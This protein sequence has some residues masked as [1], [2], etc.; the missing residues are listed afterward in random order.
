MKRLF[1]KLLLLCFIS[2][3][4]GAQTW[5][6]KHDYPSPVRTN[7]ISFTIGNFGYY[8]SGMRGSA[9]SDSTDMMKYDV[10][11]DTWAPISPL[12][13]RLLSA[14]SFSIGQY[15][16]VGIGY[17]INELP[18]GFGYDNVGT[19]SLFYRYDPMS[20]SWSTVAGFPLSS[21][22]NPS[23]FVLNGLGYVAG[24]LDS[25]RLLPQ[26]LLYSYNPINNNWAQLDSLPLHIQG[27]SGFSYNGFGYTADGGTSG[28][29]LSKGV[30]KYNASSNSWDTLSSFPGNSA[31]GRYCNFVLD[32]AIYFCNDN[33]QFWKYSPATDTWQRLPDTPFK[34]AGATFILHGIPVVIGE[35]THEVWQLCP[36]LHVSAGSEI[37]ICKGT[38]TTLLASG[39]VNYS[40][41]PSAGLTNPNSYNPGAAPS[42]TTMYVVTVTD[43]V[44]CIGRDSVRV[45]VKIVP[46]QPLISANGAILTSSDTLGNQWYLNGTAIAGAT[47]QIDTATTTG[48]YTVCTSS[49]GCSICSAPMNFTITGIPFLDLVAEIEVYPN[50]ATSEFVLSIRGKPQQDVSVELFAVTG[51]KVKTIFEGDLLGGIHDQI[52]VDMNELP[53]GSY[54]IRVSGKNRTIQ[55]MVIIEK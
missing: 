38:T 39:G 26:N 41:S 10:L 46:V 36:P 7:A 45:D 44:G 20:N 1:R 43:S 53:S 2:F 13:Q 9:A 14:A 27:A 52:R 5:V 35:G 34:Y 11:T 16:Y 50:P 19:S 33:S 31:G 32:T 22:F 37:S 17:A 18:S 4:L 23:T 47:N 48:S 55:K 28:D 3:H 54:L 15:G 30:F 29:T 25:G 21:I 42:D 49:P 24:G 51:K 6:R 12:P 8:G 40:W